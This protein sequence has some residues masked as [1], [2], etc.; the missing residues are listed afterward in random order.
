MLD[1]RDP[2]RRN[3]DQSGES[4]IHRR[5]LARQSR[6]RRR[7]NLRKAAKVA[8]ETESSRVLGVCCCVMLNEV[9]HLLCAFSELFN[10]K[11]ILRRCAPQNDTQN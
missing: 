7:S 6:N 4:R 9:K 11:Q 3:R 2:A 5:G 8:K 10:Q 1:D